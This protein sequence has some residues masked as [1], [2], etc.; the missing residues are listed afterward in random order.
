MDFKTRCRFD[1]HGQQFGVTP[2]ALVTSVPQ[3]NSG[4][5]RSH[6]LN[7]V[8]MQIVQWLLAELFN[9]DLLTLMNKMEACIDSSSS[10]MIE[11]H[12]HWS[13]P[14]SLPAAKAEPD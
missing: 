13:T 10:Y 12:Q 1:L 11:Y 8:M 2:Q 5:V 4:P 9:I 7:I 6:F 3:L 14:I